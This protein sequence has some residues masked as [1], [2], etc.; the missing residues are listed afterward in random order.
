MEKLLLLIKIL[1]DNGGYQNGNIIM[2]NY[3]N[4]RWISI[5]I[6]EGKDKNFD[7]NYFSMGKNA[8]DDY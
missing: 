3:D 2:R 4:I 7:I 6:Y 1:S 5:I 8:V